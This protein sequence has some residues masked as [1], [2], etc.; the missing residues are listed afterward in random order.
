MYIFLVFPHCWHVLSGLQDGKESVVKEVFPGDSVHS[1]LSILDVITVGYTH[2][3]LTLARTRVLRHNCKH[4]KR[5]WNCCLQ[6]T[7]VASSR[8]QAADPNDK[9]W[10]KQKC[11]QSWKFVCV[12]DF[13]GWNTSNV[14]ASC[15]LSDCLG[16]VRGKAR[17]GDRFTSIVRSPPSRTCQDTVLGRRLECIAKTARLHP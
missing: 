3:L 16:Q 15:R 9:C 7:A 8:R 12:S 5:D 17:Y 2:Y 13:F 11:I 14:R 1:L 6:L 4:S 10:S